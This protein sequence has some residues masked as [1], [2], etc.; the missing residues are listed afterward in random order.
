MPEPTDQAPEQHTP[1]PWPT[2]VIARY[3]TVAGATVDISHDMFYLHD[4]EPNVTVASCG[5][6]SCDASLT[7]KWGQH[8]YR[9]NNG[10]SGADAEAGKWAQAHA[11]KCRALPLPVVNA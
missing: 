8:A 4:T 6:E 3:L 7:E 11:E 5:G 1:E 2:G 10:S 9:G